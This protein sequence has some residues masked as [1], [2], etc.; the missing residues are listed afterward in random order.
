MRSVFEDAVLF[1]EIINDHLLLAV[2]PTGQGDNMEME[3]FYCVRHSMN[4]LFLI[5]FDHNMI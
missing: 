4:R 5:L 2:E 1:D 3:R